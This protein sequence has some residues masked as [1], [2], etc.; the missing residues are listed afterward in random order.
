M[1]VAT[2]LA[3]SSAGLHAA[4]NLILK[5]ADHEDRDL[6]IWGQMVAGALLALPVLLFVGWPDTLALPWLV[7]SST[8]HLVYATA[9][10]GAYRAGDFS[11]TYPLARGGGALV[12]ALGGVLLLGDHLPAA[13]WLAIAGVDRRPVGAGRATSPCCGSR[14]WSSAP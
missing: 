11:L 8:I 7:L 5:T 9:L 4:W 13:A 2:A 12:A 14:R 3:L 1:L 10:V 6:A